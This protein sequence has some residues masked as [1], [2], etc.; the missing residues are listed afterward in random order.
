M[1]LADA[2][3]MSN[4]V[5]SMSK[6]ETG[7]VLSYERQAM[8]GE[9]MPNDLDYADQIMFLQLRLLYHQHKIGIVDRE[10]AVR[11]KRKMLINHRGRLF[12]EKMGKYW[13][14]QIKNTELARAAY[15]KERTLENADKL[16]ACMEGGKH[17]G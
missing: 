11:E 16:L 10:T 17:Y 12:A 1:F 6:D 8:N 2:L 9:E 7:V 3:K 5:I 15:R 14:E 13:V 4:V